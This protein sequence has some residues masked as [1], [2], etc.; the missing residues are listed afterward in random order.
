MSL[1][2]GLSQWVSN[3]LDQS[4]ASSLAFADL[5]GGGLNPITD[6]TVWLRDAITRLRADLANA[7]AGSKAVVTGSVDIS[8]LNYDP[9][10][11]VLCNQTLQLTADLGGT[12]TVTFGLGAGVAPSG[13]ADV[14][15]AILAV[16]SAHQGALED[17]AGHLNLSSNTTGGTSTITVTGGSAAAALGFT[18]G[19]TSTGVSSGA[20]G[21]S[22]VSGAAIT[23]GSVTVPPGTVRSMLAYIIGQIP[24]NAAILSDTLSQTFLGPVAVDG[25]FGVQGATLINNAAQVNGTFT[26]AGN[27]IIGGTLS[28]TGLATLSGGIALGSLSCTGDIVSTAGHVTAFSTI[29]GGGLI[30]TNDVTAQENVGVGSLSPSYA[31]CLPCIALAEVSVNPTGTPLGGG[32]IF[33]ATNGSLHYVGPAGSNTTLAPP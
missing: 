2:Q 33:V 16:V 15:A 19:Q 29:T 31:G 3:I 14:V 21:I 9:I 24:L 32:I 22:L 20:D 5:Y 18:A 11:G 26:A 27:A 23:A 4:L 12:L 25:T 10:S 1:R 28:C 8:T 17:G 13:P 30:S 6:R 7:T